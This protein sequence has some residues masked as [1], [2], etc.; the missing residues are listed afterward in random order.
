MKI[1]SDETTAGVRPKPRRRRR[2]PVAGRVE[3]NRVDGVEFDAKINRFDGVAVD[4][5]D[6]AHTGHGPLAP[7]Q[8]ERRRCEAS[9][10]WVEEDGSLGAGPV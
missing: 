8:A 3:I 9:A 6:I 2:S 4:A 1:R 7:Q 5:C 10:C